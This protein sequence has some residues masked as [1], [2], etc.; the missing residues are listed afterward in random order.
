MNAHYG[1]D[2]VMDIQRLNSLG[3]SGY[4]RHPPI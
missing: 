2:C 4:F 1:E 3:A